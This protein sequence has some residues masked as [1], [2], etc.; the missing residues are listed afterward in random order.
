MHSYMHTDNTQ[1]RSSPSA[2]KA[3]ATVFAQQHLAPAAD[4][5]AAV[6]RAIEAMKGSADV[7]TAIAVLQRQ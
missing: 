6:E 4:Y 1:L 5:I 3:L 2:P 7:E